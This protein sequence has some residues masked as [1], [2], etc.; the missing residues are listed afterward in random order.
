ML[1]GKAAQNSTGKWF[2]QTKRWRVLGGSSNPL[3]EAEFSG[4]AAYLFN[5][6]CCSRV[7]VRRARVSHPPSHGYGVASSETAT[8][9][10]PKAQSRLWADAFRSARKAR[11]PSRAETPRIFL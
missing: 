3:L 8:V 5:I 10:K 9:Q 6:G 2:W 7:A 1:L 4:E 11:G